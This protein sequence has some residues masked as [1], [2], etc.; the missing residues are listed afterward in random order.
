MSSPLGT[1]NGAAVSYESS[2]AEIPVMAWPS[3]IG[4]AYEL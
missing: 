1:P 2:R 3:L 4:T